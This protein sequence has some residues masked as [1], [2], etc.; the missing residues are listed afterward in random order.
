MPVQYLKTSEVKKIAHNLDMRISQQV[1]I[2]SNRMVGELLKK[3]LKRAAQRAKENRRKTIM[4][5]DL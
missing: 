2:D 4:S 3:L 1:I 5:R